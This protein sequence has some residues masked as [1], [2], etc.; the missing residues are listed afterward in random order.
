MIESVKQQAAEHIS[1]LSGIELIAL[2]KRSSLHAYFG[3]CTVESLDYLHTL[4]ENDEFIHI[5]EHVFTVLYNKECWLNIAHLEWREY[6][7]ISG[8]AYLDRLKGS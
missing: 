2:R 1:I 4:L 5:L 6:D 8:R 7:Y 3:C